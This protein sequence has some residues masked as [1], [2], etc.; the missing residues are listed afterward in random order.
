MRETT[1]KMSSQPP[2]TIIPA[3]D[4]KSGRAVRLHQGRASQVT[5][6]GDPV[7]RA[8]EFERTGAR[9]LH[10]VDLD[11]AFG[12]GDNRGIV[13][14][15]VA[16]VDISVEVSGGLRDSDSVARALDTGAH[17]VTL[18]TAAVENPTWAASMIEKYTDRIVIGLDVRDGLV[19]THGWTKSAGPMVELIKRFEE[20]G[21]RTYMV[22]DI[23]KD[24]TLTGPNL[25]LLRE[26]AALTSGA[27]IA[28]GGV[29]SLEDIASLRELVSVGVKGVIIGKAFYEGFFTVA[30]ACEV[31]ERS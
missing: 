29:A 13:E 22:T 25:E 28:S 20:V 31:A 2:L 12:A 1:E 23:S 4:I 10:V 16:K 11:A 24:G 19:A 30:E 27:I 21:C 5:D 18:G 3:I 14:S 7:E 6:Y 9:W 8:Y 15:I 26:S 17:R